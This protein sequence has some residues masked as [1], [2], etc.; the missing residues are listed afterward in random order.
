LREVV[1]M[2]QRRGPRRVAVAVAEDEIVLRALAEAIE[3][4]L[5]KPLLYGRASRIEAAAR[6]AGVDPSSETGRALLQEIK[7][8]SDEASAVEA[9]V[10]ACRSGEAD[11]VMKGHTDSGT[12]LRAVLDRDRGLRAGGMLSHVAVVEVAGLDRL[13]FIT[14]GGLNVLPDLPRKRAIVEN[15]IHV[16][17][18]CG[19]AHPRIAALAAV[20][21]V[22]PE[23]PATVDGAALAAAA[24]DGAFAGAE[25]DGP[26]ALDLALSSLAAERKGFFSPVAGRADILLVPNIETG[27]ILTKGLIYL[28]GAKVGGVVVG[29]TAPVILLSRADEA[30]TKLHSMAIGVLLCR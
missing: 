3:H 23:M 19:V 25:L 1:E 29:A 5:A 20:E 30:E 4:G 22:T 18:A 8:Q 7:D 2:A 28:A 17:R 14:D 6:A 24:R 11:M 27:N 13:L 12:L 15:A 21:T 26:L 10:A 16:A 9:A